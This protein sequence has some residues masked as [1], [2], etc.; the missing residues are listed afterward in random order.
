MWQLRRRH[1]AQRP[2]GQL[3]PFIRPQQRP[4]FAPPPWHGPRTFS[5]AHAFVSKEREENYVWVLE[6]T[7]S[8]LNKCMEPRVI[9]TDRD[10]AVMNA[11][12]KVFPEAAK[13]L[14]RWHID[15][16]IA[17]H[18]K[19]SFSDADW[20][21]FKDLIFLIYTHKYQPFLLPPVP[22][23]MKPMDDIW[24]DI[25]GLSSPTTNL[26]APVLRPP[27]DSGNFLPP[28]PSTATMLTLFTTPSNNSD[29]VDPNKRPKPNPHPQPEHSEKFRRLMKNRES[30]ARSRAR[31]QVT[32]FLLRSVS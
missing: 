6:M 19:E 8:M 21:K 17:K 20:K 18:C 3:S 12:R 9:I 25:S 27:G 4:S 24:N 1:S 31:K 29:D 16:N 28:P 10:L 32:Y 22:F 11:C 5:I 30:A 2:F 26:F 7:K 14:C 13:Y 23:T 15:E